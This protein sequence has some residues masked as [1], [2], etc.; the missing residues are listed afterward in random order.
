MSE[1]LGYKIFGG[2]KDELLT[3]VFQKK[4]KVNI[5]SGNPEVLYNGLKDDQLQENFNDERSI[6]I[7]D[8]I[9]VV[10]TSKLLRDPVRE[11]IA[12]IEVMEAIIQRC[13]SD[14]KSIYLLG[15]NQ[16]VVENCRSKLLEKYPK[17]H[18]AGI[19]NGYFDIDNCESI[20]DEINAASPEALFVA[21]GSPKQDKFITK[22]MQRLNVRIFMGVGGSFDVLAGKV[23]RAPEWML[24]CNLEWLYRVYKEPFRIKRLGAIPKFMWKAITDR[25]SGGSK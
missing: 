23:N 25:R 10:Y 16:A 9:G 12:G 5:I 3:T 7:P 4:D 20:I 24:Q 19:H 8:G 13:E 17:L 21:M 18:I 1:I 15:A 2:S 6:I 22:Y 11:K 14:G